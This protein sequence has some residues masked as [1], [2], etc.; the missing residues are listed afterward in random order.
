MIMIVREKSIRPCLFF[1]KWFQTT[2]YKKYEYALSI[3]H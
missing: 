2:K 3:R 1:I